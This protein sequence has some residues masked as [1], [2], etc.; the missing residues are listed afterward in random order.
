MLSTKL[1]AVTSFKNDRVGLSGKIESILAK[2]KLDD[3]SFFTLMSRTDLNKIIA[4][5]K[6][7]NSGLME[8]STAVEVGRLMGAQG[9]YTEAQNFYGV[10]DNLMIE[11]VDEINA[12]VLRIQ[13]AIHKHKIS[14]EQMER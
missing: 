8:A 4:E 13:T 11:P 12:A 5:Q 3:K 10:A 1:I 6:I 7:Q 9:K 2:Q 14:Q